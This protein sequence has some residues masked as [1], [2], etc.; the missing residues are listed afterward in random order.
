MD[1]LAQCTDMLTSRAVSIVTLNH[2]HTCASNK[3][4][5]RELGLYRCAKIPHF[6][7]KGGHLLASVGEYL[8]KGVAWSHLGQ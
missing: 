4:L 1:P 6:A 5:A 2:L 8:E 3:M 7:N